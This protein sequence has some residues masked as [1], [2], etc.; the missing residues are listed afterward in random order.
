MGSDAF[1]LVIDTSTTLNYT[2]AWQMLGRSSRRRGYAAGQVIVR[3]D[4]DDICSDGKRILEARE[5][6]NEDSG[7][8]ILNTFLKLREDNTYA[9]DGVRR[10]LRE[11]NH[12]WR[13]NLD[14]IGDLPDDIKQ[15]IARCDSA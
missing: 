12:G 5:M 7:L 10:A 4:E 13:L 2:T 1:V 8:S 11:Y 14:Q 9:L 3:K 15:A 6:A